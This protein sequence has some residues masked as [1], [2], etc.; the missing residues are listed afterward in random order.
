[1]SLLILLFLLFP[2]KV[3]VSLTALLI[4]FFL[5]P[6]KVFGKPHV[7]V[8]APQNCFFQ[9]ELSPKIIKS[10]IGIVH[11]EGV[12]EIQYGLSHNRR[13]AEAERRPAYREERPPPRRA[14]IIMLLE[15]GVAHVPLSLSPARRRR[16]QPTL[17]H[18]TSRA[19]RPYP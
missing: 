12:Q 13:T 7:F 9:E 18:G 1:M 6:N 19:H 4:G 17:P 10:D 2:H 16:A 8:F 3:F 14:Y 11:S 5:S 15:V